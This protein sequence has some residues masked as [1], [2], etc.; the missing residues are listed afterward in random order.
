MG[1]VRNASMEKAAGVQKTG[2]TGKGKWVR[3]LC[4]GLAFFLVVFAFYTT[5]MGE[6]LFTDETDNFAVGDIIA[7]GGDVYKV[8]VSQH[9]PFSYY[10]SAVITL[11]VHPHNPYMY[12]FCLYILLSALWTGMFFHYKKHINPAALVLLPLLYLTELGLYTNG[13][14]M[15]SEHWAGIGHAILLLELLCYAKT[16]RLHLSNCIWISASILLSFGCV[17]S[18]AYSVAFVAAGVFLYQ[19]W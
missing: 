1:K 17:F 6:D 12:R 19:I 5:F 7:R 2:L 14:M 13:S 9:M 10:I 15:I 4:A 11:L 16:N 18:S 3:A 8:S